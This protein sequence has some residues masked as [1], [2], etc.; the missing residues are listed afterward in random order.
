SVFLNGTSIISTT[1]TF[2]QTASELG[3]RAV[4][5]TQS[6]FDNFTVSDLATG[7]TGTDGSTLFDLKQLLYSDSFIAEDTKQ[8]LYADA[9]TFFDTLQ[10][11]YVNGS[12]PF[13][14]LFQ[15]YQ[16]SNVQLDA[17]LKIYSDSATAF[18]TLQELFSGGIVGSTP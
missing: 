2:N 17:K 7:G 13:D 8:T 11:L 14:L 10:Q 9:S 18:D 16:D 15:L 12:T 3:L 6:T 4:N 5:D 1:E